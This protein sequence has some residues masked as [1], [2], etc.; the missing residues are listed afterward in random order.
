MA[1]ANSSVATNGYA[2][3]A[4][5]VR[6]TPAPDQNAARPWRVC[7]VPVFDSCTAARPALLDHLVGTGEHRRRD[8]DPE[9]LRGLHVDE[10][11]EMCRLL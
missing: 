10:E 8:G 9:R 1:M 4:F 11:F 2:S 3:A 7:S 5:L 6:Y